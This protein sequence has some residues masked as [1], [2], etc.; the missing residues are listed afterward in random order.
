MLRT[1]L[2]EDFEV[3]EW[4]FSVVFHASAVPSTFVQWTLLAAA[5]FPLFKTS[6][7]LANLVLLFWRGVAFWFFRTVFR[8][9]LLHNI[10]RFVN[11]NMG[12]G[13]SQFL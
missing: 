9:Y 10:F 2:D 4:A 3:E 7:C 13:N 12:Q 5:F 8:F 6:I 1:D 11:G